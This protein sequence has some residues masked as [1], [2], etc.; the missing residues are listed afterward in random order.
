MILFTLRQGLT[1]TRLS[2]PYRQGKAGAKAAVPLP[3]AQAAWKG[4]Q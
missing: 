4:T 3:F 1:M 2:L